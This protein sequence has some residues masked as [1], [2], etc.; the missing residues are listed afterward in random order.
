MGRLSL[1]NVAPHERQKKGRMCTVGLRRVSLSMHGHV[2]IVSGWKSPN[3]NAIR[4]Q[5]WYCVY[6]SQL[7]ML[8][9]VNRQS[10]I[11]IGSD[12]HKILIIW[13][14]P[15][16][17]TPFTPCYCSYGTILSCQLVQRP[18]RT[19]CFKS[20]LYLLITYS[21]NKLPECLACVYHL[22]K[23]WKQLNVVKM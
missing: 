7:L 2:R 14:S 9:Q 10:V 22:A 15:S 3:D 1:A 13:P 8:I 21:S 6:A 18:L 19:F 20:V 11:D 17:L 23:S 5:L 16:N 12:A 4:V